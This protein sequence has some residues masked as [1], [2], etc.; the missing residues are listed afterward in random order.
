MCWKICA[1]TAITSAGEQSG[2]IIFREYMPTGDGELGH[3][4]DAGDE[5]DRRAAECAGR[6]DARD[7]QVLLNVAADR[8]M[9]EALHE[10]PEME[11]LIEECEERLGDT[12]RIFDSGKRHR[13]ADPGDGGGRGRCPSSG[14]WPS[15]WRPGARSC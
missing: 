12:G 7:P 4:A 2:H 9:K 14:S 10:S 3:P 1:K 15:G 5:K 6:A 13:T 11:A 8:D